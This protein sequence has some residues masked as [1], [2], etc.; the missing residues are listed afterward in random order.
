MQLCATIGWLLLDGVPAFYQ[1]CAP[2]SPRLS[3]TMPAVT[4]RRPSRLRLALLG[5]GA[6]MLVVTVAASP[7]AQSAAA[8]PSPLTAGSLVLLANQPGVDMTGVLRNALT[9]PDPAIRVVAA[10][11]T[12]VLHI[13]DLAPDIERA[14]TAETN[15]QVSGEQVRSLLLLDEPAATSAVERY[16]PQASVPGALAYSWW[17]ARAHPDQMPDVI[18]M[19]ADAM[20]HQAYRLLPVLRADAR[21]VPA[22][23]SQMFA[24]YVRNITMPAARNAIWDY[25]GTEPSDTAFFRAALTSDREGVREAA[26]WR[27]IEWLAQGTQIDDDL[28]G[29]ALSDPGVVTVGALTWEQFGREI[30]DRE[31]RGTIT[32]DRSAWLKT[33][34]AAH[35]AEARPLG[36]LPRVT[37]AERDALRAA[38]GSTFR[39]S[40]PVARQPMTPRPSVQT[41]MRTLPVLWPGLLTSV[42]EAAGC[43][44]TKRHQ[45]ESMTVSYR[46]DG[47]INSLV[48]APD[49]TPTPCA[50]AAAA[51]AHLL[52]ADPEISVA[53]DAPQTVLVPIQK[54]VVACVDRP[55]VDV[56]APNDVTV[57]PVNLSPAV[58]QMVRPVYPE[59]QR[60]RRTELDSWMHATVARTGCVRA[61]S[62]T[63][64]AG[65]AFDAN[66]IDATLHWRFKPFVVGEASREVIVT[67]VQEFLPGK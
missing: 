41:P 67:V 9:N 47:R 58:D 38:L 60:R 21:R 18:P 43:R 7:R 59:G 57:P 44:T 34:A 11:V 23:A 55:A 2:Y 1:R 8:T 49:T 14:L 25:L 51:L 52:L 15:A 42:F 36:R 64:S 63:R 56:P 28:V 50:T 65:A 35:Q 66:A 33:T 4:A 45:Y 6:A 29:A 40:P 24:S 19:L 16:L 12:G 61:I 22:L 26:V 20:G 17:L 27:L 30:I 39:T 13:V 53:T 62:I 48:T 37:A 32:P 54:D 31:T 10:R 5:L 3:S 46:P